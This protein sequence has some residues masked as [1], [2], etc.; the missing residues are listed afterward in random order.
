MVLVS[1]PLRSGGPTQNGKISFNEELSWSLRTFCFFDRIRDG[2]TD[3]HSRRILEV[4]ANHRP[5]VARHDVISART[6]QCVRAANIPTERQ[7]HRC[8]SNGDSY[9]SRSDARVCR[10]SL[11]DHATLLAPLHRDRSAKS[12]SNSASLWRTLLA[13]ACSWR[14]LCLTSLPRVGDSY[15]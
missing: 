10:E 2:K 12:G 14:V 13:M 3:R 9:F 4:A 5:G 15:C 8:R 6:Q 7:P 11:L 1:F